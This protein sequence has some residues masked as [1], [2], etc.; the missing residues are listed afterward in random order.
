MPVIAMAAVVGFAEQTDFT[1]RIELD[2]IAGVNN[3]A[4][5]LSGVFTPNDSAAYINTQLLLFV[6]AFVLSEWGVTFVASDTV[7]LLR[8]LQEM[9][10]VQSLGRRPG[11]LMGW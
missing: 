1:F 11:W 9:V 10:D 8:P 3:R 6:K 5:V 7:K 4:G 2:I